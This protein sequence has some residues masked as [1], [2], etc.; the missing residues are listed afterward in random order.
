MDPKAAL[1]NH[2][3]INNPLADGPLCAYSHDR[4]LH[5][6]TKKVFLD[7]IICIGVTLEPTVWSIFQ[8]HEVLGTLVQ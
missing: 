8:C 7:R 6:L 3:Q 5:P 1:N 2:L 4:G